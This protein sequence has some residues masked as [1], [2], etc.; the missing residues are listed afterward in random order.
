M[1]KEVKHQGLFT[2]HD[3][4]KVTDLDNFEHCQLVF[5]TVKFCSCRFEEKYF[6]VSLVPVVLC[7]DVIQIVCIHQPLWLCFHSSPASWACRLFSP[8]LSSLNPFTP[9]SPFHTSFRHSERDEI[10]PENSGLFVKEGLY[11]ETVCS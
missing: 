2:Y 10:R 6:D 1:E 11:Y 8:S 9:L 4:S 5:V 3:L 7:K